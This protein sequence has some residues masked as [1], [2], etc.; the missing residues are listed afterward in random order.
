MSCDAMVITAG[1]DVSIMVQLQSCQG[2][3]YAGA[4]AGSVTASLVDKRNASTIN[5]SA[6]AQSDS[7]NA[8]WAAGTIEVLFSD[9]DTSAMSV[10]TYYLQVSVVEAGGDIRKILVKRDVAVRSVTA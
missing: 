3:A 6:V 4:L 1:E 9:S 2:L 5:G 7:G 8:N 10:G